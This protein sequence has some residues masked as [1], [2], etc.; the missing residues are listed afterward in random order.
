MFFFEQEIIWMPHQQ[1]GKVKEM[2]NHCLQGRSTLFVLSNHSHHYQMPSHLFKT[3][4]HTVYK[5]KTFFNWLFVFSGGS[6]VQTLTAEFTILITIQVEV[7]GKDLNHYHQGK[8]NK[9]LLVMKL[10]RHATEAVV[11]WYTSQLRFF[12]ITMV[13]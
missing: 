12:F 2:R 3:L 11:M 10:L 1:Q 6:S 4:T 7:H 13:L 9:E 8:L 5:K